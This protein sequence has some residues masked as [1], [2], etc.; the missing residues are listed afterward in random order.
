MNEPT[1]EGTAQEK[2]LYELIWKRTIASQMAD[3][4][5]EKTTINI[6]I[7]NTSEKFVATGEV[8][9]FDGFLKVYLESTDDEEHAED[10]SHILPA[11]KE[12]DELQ[13]REILCYREVFSGSCK[14]HRGQSGEETGRSSA[15]AVHLPMLQPSVPSS[16][17]NTW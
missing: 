9:S 2:R 6:N 3:A 11:L 12:G 16:S 14:I 5:L 15:S 17:V 8:V 10:S 4:Q 7:G 13:R 1:I